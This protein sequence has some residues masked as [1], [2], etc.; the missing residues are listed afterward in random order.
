MLNSARIGE[1]RWRGKSCPLREER[2]T[3]SDGAAKRRDAFAESETTLVTSWRPGDD[4]S[5]SS[6]AYGSGATRR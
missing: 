3:R 4:F 5:E 2:G 1:G 6:G